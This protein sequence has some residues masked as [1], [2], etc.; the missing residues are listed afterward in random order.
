MKHQPF[1]GRGPDQNPVIVRRLPPRRTHASGRQGW[2][3]GRLPAREPEARK[4]PLENAPKAPHPPAP[5]GASLAIP[6][7]RGRVTSLDAVTRSVTTT[8]L[9]SPHAR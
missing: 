1:R 5:H 9:P 8:A 7:Q 6:I 3:E 4:P 2:R